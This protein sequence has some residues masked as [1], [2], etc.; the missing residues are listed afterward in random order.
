MLD[1]EAAGL[2]TSIGN[3][4][5]MQNE[6]K[7][8]QHEIGKSNRRKEKQHVGWISHHHGE[9]RFLP[10]WNDAFSSTERTYRKLYIKT[11]GQD[12]CARLPIDAA[13]RASVFTAR[14]TQQL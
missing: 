12:N 6:K 7:R 11:D 4:A 5:R 1:R 8:R 13:L 9:H 3:Q 2:Q 10:R 14:L